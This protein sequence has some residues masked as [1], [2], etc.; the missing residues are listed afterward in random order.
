MCPFDYSM[1]CKQC[2]QDVPSLSSIK[3]TVS[4]P[5][6]FTAVSSCIIPTMLPSERTR[7]RYSTPSTILSS[8]MFNVTTVELFPTEMRTSWFVCSNSKSEDSEC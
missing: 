1:Q 5:A 7:V 6:V 2:T 8:S 4:A 3:T